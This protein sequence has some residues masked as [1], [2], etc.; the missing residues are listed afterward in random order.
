VRELRN[1][2]ERLFIFNPGD[3]WD[4]GALEISGFSSGG[5]A[6]LRTSAMASPSDDKEAIIDALM[7]CDGKQKDA[8]RLLGISESTLTR[9]IARLRLQVYT[10]KGR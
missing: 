8:A 5:P 10:R 1:L 6:A 2:I 4:A 9:K 7:V 3:H